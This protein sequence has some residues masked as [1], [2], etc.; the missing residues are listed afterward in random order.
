MGC[1]EWVE[2]ITEKV[3]ES[4]MNLE[5]TF[6][7]DL[8]MLALLSWNWVWFLVL[9]ISSIISVILSEIVH[10]SWIGSGELGGDMMSLTMS[11]LDTKEETLILIPQQVEAQSALA[12]GHSKKRCA[13][14]SSPE[15]QM[16]HVGSIWSS[17]RFRFTFVGRAST[18]ILHNNI[19]NLLGNVAF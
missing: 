9:Q 17:L 4:S 16:M 14:D 2:F 13:K 7:F 1:T 3:L 6:C 8:W 5:S 15:L 18:P 12:N 19:F 10:W 11:S